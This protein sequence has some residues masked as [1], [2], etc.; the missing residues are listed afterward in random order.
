M[1]RNRFATVYERMTPD[2][3]YLY[4]YAPNCAMMSPAE[5]SRFS[6]ACRMAVHIFFCH[7]IEAELAKK[8]G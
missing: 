2:L 5:R 6:F 3:L 1:I 7:P 8:F 4:V